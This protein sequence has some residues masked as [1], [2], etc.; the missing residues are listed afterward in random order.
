MIVECFIGCVG[1]IYTFYTCLFCCD[2]WGERYKKY[3]LKKMNYR[4]VSLEIPN[5]I[6]E[7]KI[8]RINGIVHGT[9]I[10]GKRK[11][12]LYRKSKRHKYITRLNTIEEDEI[13]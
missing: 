1:S 6:P 8:E 13:C 11:N 4:Q 7:M 5:Q 10:G 9:T 3:K 12:K 2:Y